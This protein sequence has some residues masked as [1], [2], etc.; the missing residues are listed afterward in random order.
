MFLRR[1]GLVII[2]SLF[3][4]H[5]AYAGDLIAEEAVKYYNAG[6]KAQK[7][8]DLFTANENYAKTLFVD[9]HNLMWQKY[10]TLNRGIIFAKQGDFPDAEQSF[11]EVL[12]IDPDYKLAQMNLGLVYEKT[13]PRLEAMEYWMKFF[14][15]QK[16]KPLDYVVQEGPPEEELK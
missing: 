12:K 3:F 14:E 7:G 5:L 6:V 15:L 8:G 2:V 10:I 11:N 13:R 16:L 1:A 4:C 9:P